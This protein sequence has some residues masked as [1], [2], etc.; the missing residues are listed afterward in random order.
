MSITESP[1]EDNVF[2]KKKLTGDIEK[3]LESHE[4]HIFLEENLGKDN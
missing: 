4:K 3:D 1:R 2:R